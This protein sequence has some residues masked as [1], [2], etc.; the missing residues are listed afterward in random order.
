MAYV[1]SQYV[2]Y[3]MK[4]KCR[5][6]IV[7]KYFQTGELPANG[8]IY[9]IEEYLFNTPLAFDIATTEINV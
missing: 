2:A 7:R 3:T 1:V 4:S 6:E 5:T 9:K 8:T